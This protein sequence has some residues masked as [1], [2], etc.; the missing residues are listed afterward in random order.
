VSSSLNKI[1]WNSLILFALIKNYSTFVIYSNSYLFGLLYN[2]SEVEFINV[3]NG[4]QQWI[5]WR[6][7]NVNNSLFPFHCFPVEY[8]GSY[9][10]ILLGV[11][12][13]EVLS[14]IVKMLRL[15]VRLPNG[16]KV[17]TIVGDSELWDFGFLIA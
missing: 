16:E 14:E 5:C 4:E 10:E 12:Y 8:F 15:S 6:K 1:A 7:S 3:K 17:L 13:Y 11:D 9:C 2:F